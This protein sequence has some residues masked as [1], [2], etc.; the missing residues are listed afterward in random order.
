MKIYIKK[1]NIKFKKSTE[2]FNFKKINYI[3]GQMGAGKTS[4]VK[5]I[6]YCLAGD[7]DYTP[8]MQ[9]EFIS[10]KLLI[11]IE[12]KAL[13]LE[14][15]KDSNQLVA[16]FKKNREIQ[17]L[18][19]P[20]EATTES[21]IIDNQIYNLSDFI[22]Y[23][24]GITPP[25]VRKSKIKEDSELQRLSVRNLLWY[26]YLD[27]DNID[28]TFFYLENEHTFKR[29]A[30]RDV[31]RFVIG[32]H[33]EKV[34]EL[35]Q[36]LAELR[37]KRRDL[38]TASI[39]LQNIFE[40]M[41]IENEDEIQKQ[42]KNNEVKLDKIKITID[43]YKNDNSELINTH[44]T[45]ELKNKLRYVYTE[46]ES[47]EETII[48]IRDLID[49]DTRHIN[50]I[51][52]LQLKI[53]RSQEA[54]KILNGINYQYC[55]ACAQELE[56]Y[57]DHICN[58]CGKEIKDVSNVLE[59][60]VKVDSDQRIYEL[61]DSLKRHKKQYKILQNKLKNINEEKLSLDEKLNKTLIEYDSAYLSNI[62]NIEEKKYEL[63]EKIKSLN[64]IKSLPA[65][66]SKLMSDSN[67]L[68]PDID[69][70]NENLKKLRI[71]AEKDT[72]NL[73]ILE[74]KF[75]EYLQI[76]KFPGVK[77]NDFVQIKSPNFLPEVFDL[78]IGDLATTSFS[79]VSSGGKKTLFKCCFSLALHYLSQ[80]NSS[81]LPSFLIIDSPMKNIS[82]RENIEQF[83]S[84]IGMLYE[85][86]LNELKD[87]Q[88]F[89]IDKE[90][91]L[92]K[93]EDNI[94]I[95]VR[96]MKP[97]STEFPPLIPYYTGH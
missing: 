80:K 42:I 36:E 47:L 78:N 13:W 28:S 91:Y 16:T 68:T 88:L 17:T 34:A 40:E 66:A 37:E 4:V 32:F 33:Q 72:K 45:D 85:L 95:F 8:A 12:G 46:I 44:Y 5:L 30:S 92:P 21:I 2:V 59:T 19:I 53:D 35:E 77:K 22:Y 41:G 7:I 82:E 58:V 63:Q 71:D 75:L 67:D 62:L 56:K 65:K 79:N 69:S 54:R 55:P 24:S 9:Q 39:S 29:L 52:M 31:L 14:R 20:V 6:D 81:I 3:Y 87:L 89:I 18:I 64:K 97:N 38:K 84:F 70:K 83:E 93:K 61:N 43:E 25:K 74:E 86:H 76:S 49:K 10:V 60:N 48:E 94:D 26:S 51:K 57:P 50:E 73:K 90:I 23:F 11:I 27:Q 96:H 1:M 15:N